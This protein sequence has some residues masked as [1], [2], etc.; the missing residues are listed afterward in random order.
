[1]EEGF[2]EREVVFLK[3]LQRKIFKKTTSRSIRLFFGG[4]AA[5]PIVDFITRKGISGKT[6]LFDS[7]KIV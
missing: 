5:V 4:K 3:I 7:I 6:K 1:V 2:L